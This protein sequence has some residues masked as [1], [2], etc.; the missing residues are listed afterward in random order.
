MSQELIRIRCLQ[1]ANQRVGNCILCDRSVADCRCNVRLHYPNMFNATRPQFGTMFQGDQARDET[2]GRQRDA[3]SNEDIVE[4][5][6]DETPHDGRQRARNI[7]MNEGAGRGERR[8]PRERAHRQGNNPGRIFESELNNNKKRLKKMIAKETYSTTK[9]IKPDG[10]MVM[11]ST[12]TPVFEA[13]FH[14]E[15]R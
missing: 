2:E 7:S 13:E 5:G 8:N 1:A 10:T 3:E 6:R 4:N 11:N 14:G 9:T 12:Y 15:P